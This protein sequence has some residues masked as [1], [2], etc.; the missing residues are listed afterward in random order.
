MTDPPALKAF[1]N[2]VYEEAFGVLVDLRHFVAE[3]MVGS[4]ADIPPGSKTLVVQEVSRATRRIA[5]VMAWLLL[6]KAIQAG[7]LGR[8]AAA[9]HAASQIT[10]EPFDPANPPPEELEKLPFALRG[11]ID[12]SRRVHEKTVKFKERGEGPSL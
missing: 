5:D 2:T 9:S 12:R 8:D 11:L 7:E 1:L 4:H 6:Q 3:E 10:S